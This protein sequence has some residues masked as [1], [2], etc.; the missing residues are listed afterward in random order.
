MS[1][2]EQT[3]ERLMDEAIDLAI[4]LQSDPENPVSLKVIQAWR[5]RGPDNE[6]VWQRV[7]RIHG[8]SGQILGE[9]RKAER[10]DGLSRRNFIVGAAVAF[11]VT[12]AGYFVVPGALVRARADHI[13]GTAEILKVS[14]PDGSNV[15][16]GPSS[17]IA[18][19]F[20]PQRRQ[21]E[22]LAGMAFFDVGEETSRAFSVKASELEITAQSARFDV[23][24]D[25]DMRMVGVEHGVVEASGA[26]VAMGFHDG[27]VELG[28]GQWAMLDAGSGQVTRGT[29]DSSLIASWRNNLIV[30]ERQPVSA[31]VA[32]V[33]HWMPGRIVMADPFISQQLVSGVF[34]LTDPIRALEAVVHPVGGQVRQ[35]SSFLTVISPF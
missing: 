2:V 9:Q 29:R 32:R 24:S 11:G 27:P 23:V 7:A 18:F 13:T 22:L 14:L 26:E 35:I 19:S 4:R 16:L 28:S 5:A 12:G 30:A 31:L 15:T 25:A 1:K 21:V 6:R 20:T 34:D 17:A 8:A 10:H 33:G 3:D